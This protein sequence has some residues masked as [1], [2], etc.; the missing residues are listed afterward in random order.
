MSVSAGQHGGHRGPD[1]LSACRCLAHK[2]K[3]GG[4]G[5]LCWLGRAEMAK[6]PRATRGHLLVAVRGWGCQERGC[7]ETKLGESGCHSDME[8]S[9]MTK[10][11]QW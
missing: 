4:A 7:L 1:I 2:V 9:R 11:V 8:G 3:V 10:K 5:F 6:L